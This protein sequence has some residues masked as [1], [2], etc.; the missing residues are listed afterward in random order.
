M[1]FAE[2]GDAAAI[3]VETDHVE[4]FGKGNREREPDIAKA[5]DDEL[6]HGGTRHFRVEETAPARRLH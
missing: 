5:D 1:P 4:A 6:G 3:D 2:L